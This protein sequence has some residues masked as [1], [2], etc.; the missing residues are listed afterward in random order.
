MAKNRIN[1]LV[2]VQKLVEKGIDKIDVSNQLGVSVKTIE[3]DLLEIEKLKNSSLSPEIQNEKRAE[4]YLKLLEA[5]QDIYENYLSCV[6]DKNF[7]N[8]NRFFSNFLSAMSKMMELFS[9][10]GGVGVAVQV[11]LPQGQVQ[12]SL[13]KSIADKLSKAIIDNH[14][15]KA[16]ITN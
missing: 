10:S 8:A 5:S 14:E 7:L 2:E 11:N 16:G 4:F 6:K 9:L 3:R 12:D 15:R 13:P 1:R